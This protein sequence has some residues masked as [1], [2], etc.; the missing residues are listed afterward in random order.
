M[1]KNISAADKITRLLIATVIAILYFT[2]RIQGTFAI[3]LGIAAIIIAATALINFCPIYYI[4]GISTKKT[5]NHE[6]RN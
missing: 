1:K 5:N 6:T 4:L 3:F 2:E